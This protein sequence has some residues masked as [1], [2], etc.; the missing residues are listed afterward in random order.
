M[1]HKKDL[2]KTEQEELA[3][4]I[5]NILNLDADNSIILYDIDHNTEIKDGIMNLVPELRKYFSYNN[6]NGL[7]R[8]ER[9]KRPYLSLIRQITKVKYSMTSEDIRIDREGQ[10]IRTKRYS[11]HLD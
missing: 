9:M 1:R 3:D 2:Y 5:I 11:F 8:P 4:T 10:I 7:T 6:I